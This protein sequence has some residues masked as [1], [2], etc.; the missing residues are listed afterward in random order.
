MDRGRLGLR[1]VREDV[2]L[3]G[4][5][6]IDVLWQEAAE[7]AHGVREEFDESIPD[8]CGQEAV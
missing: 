3:V 4:R 6:A 8:A 5:D 7:A 2:D 1:S